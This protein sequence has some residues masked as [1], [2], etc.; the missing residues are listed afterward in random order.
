MKGGSG[1]RQKTDTP[2]IAAPAPAAPAPVI[3]AP[4]PAAPAPV[5]AVPPVNWYTPQSQQQEHHET[6]RERLI[7]ETKRSEALEKQRFA[8]QAEQTANQVD[9]DMVQL[10]TT[11]PV[12]AKFIGVGILRMIE[13]VLRQEDKDDTEIAV[14]MTELMKDGI[15]IQFSG[16]TRYISTY[17]LPLEKPTKTSPPGY[18]PAAEYLQV[19]ASDD[20]FAWS[21][22]DSNTHGIVGFFPAHQL[23]S[24]HN[25]AP[26]DGDSGTIVKYL[27]GVKNLK[28][29]TPTKTNIKNMG[30]HSKVLFITNP[31]S[32][33][34]GVVHACDDDSDEITKMPA[35]CLASKA[36][37]IQCKPCAHPEFDRFH[38]AT[39]KQSQSE[40]SLTF[41][42]LSN[43]KAV[44]AYLSNLVDVGVSAST[45][46]NIFALV[47]D[48]TIPGTCIICDASDD[49]RVVISGVIDDRY[50]DIFNTLNTKLTLFMGSLENEAAV[51]NGLGEDIK[52]QCRKDKENIYNSMFKSNAE[53]FAGVSAD[54]R[55][56]RYLNDPQSDAV[57]ASIGGPTYKRLDKERRPLWLVANRYKAEQLRAEEAASE[58]KLKIKERPTHAVDMSRL[59]A[60]QKAEEEAKAAKEAEKAT[61]IATANEQLEAK[62]SRMG[63]DPPCDWVALWSRSHD[64]L[65]YYNGKTKKSVWIPPI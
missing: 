6:K 17:D 34:N 40:L 28:R 45:Q 59:F 62:W 14:I 49:S 11:T 22:N 53:H 48:F 13:E 19:Y 31:N 7:Y 25:Y 30:S 32:E 5:I 26:I 16:Y 24:N 33:W 15:G 36:Y 61:A 3:A 63:N 46:F 12:P 57:Y 23:G 43:K 56:A 42:Q 39:S 60:A 29:T 21:G 4:A 52:Q 50:Q 1:K 41:P 38:R 47:D 37:D 54:V 20:R 51:M 27:Q 10:I 44:S 65:Y 8:T 58:A 2:F 55:Y 35:R 64:R 9:H 18:S